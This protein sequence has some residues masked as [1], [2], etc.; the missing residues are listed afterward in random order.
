MS[1][2]ITPNLGLELPDIGADENAWGDILNNDLRIIDSETASRTY[3]DAATADLSHTLMDDLAS[4][5]GEGGD[6]DT[7]FTGDLTVAGGIIAQGD[8]SSSLNVTAGAAVIGARIF[9]FRSDAGYGGVIGSW[10]TV[11][12]KGG[13][14]QLNS[15]TDPARLEFGAV[16]PASGFLSPVAMT[17]TRSGDLAAAGT[18]TAANF[19]TNGR[20]S[21]ADLAATGGAVIGGTAIVGGALAVGASAN[22]T[23]NLQLTGPGGLTMQGAAVVGGALAVGASA[24]VTGNLTVT[25]DSFLDGNAS[26]GGILVVGGSLA[27]AQSVTVG[28]FLNV[29]G[30]MR[31]NG[32]S[33][34]PDNAAAVAGGHVVGDVYFNSTS[35]ALSVVLG[36]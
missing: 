12:G 35:N 7:A 31:L 1:D 3:V 28:N 5:L 36:P 17:L 13:G 8:I 11:T 26:V 4:G 14:I 10:N 29:T 34:F 32:L 21:A 15:N 25:Q 33:P 9:A 30:G 20:V 23:G 18:V 27:A 19:T 2:V 22:I 6:G 16:D 24:N